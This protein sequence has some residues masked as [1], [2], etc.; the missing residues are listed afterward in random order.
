MSFKFKEERPNNGLAINYIE[1][2]KFN[3]EAIIIRFITPLD[4]VM[5]QQYTAVVSML[6]ESSAAFPDKALMAKQTAALYGASLGS[7]SYK[8]GDHLV[9]GLSVS[10]ID[11]RCTIDG[12]CITEKCADLILGC[13]FEPNF[14][15]GMFDQSCFESKK[16][17]MID[18]IKSSADNRHAHAIKRAREIAFEGEPAA[19]DKL[20]TL[21]GA[22][23]LKNSEL[24]KAWRKMLDEAFISISF[25]GGGRNKSA[26]RMVIDRF[27]ELCGKRGFSGELSSLNAPSPCKSSPL[28]V[29]E[30]ISQAQSKL[31]IVYKICGENQTADSLAC[32][33]LGGSAFS[34][35]FVNVREKLSL[36]YYCQSAIVDCKGAMMVDSGV[37]PGNEQR[38]RDEIFA[39]LDELRK[40]HFTDDELVNAKKYMKSSLRATYDA[41]EDLNSWY[42]S[43][44]AK[45]NVISI[46]EQL[47]MIDAITRDEVIK[48]AEGFKLDLVYILKPQE[49]E[50]ATDE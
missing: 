22:Q 23:R 25:C 1:D 47:K 17:E 36:C 14:Q 50:G 40:G 6:A 29:T 42:F 26:Q 5:P 44:F 13:I 31:I 2:D 4:E 3:T 12:E 41:A 28:E 27:N 45:G 37:A 33:M 35:L 24:V 49:D 38:A 48:S 9:A 46:D 34:K 7:F 16:R 8:M 30:S 32:V 43:R 20:G 19:E 10:C 15:D 39:Q 11:D 21:E 18:R